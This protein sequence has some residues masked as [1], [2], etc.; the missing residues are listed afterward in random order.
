MCDFSVAICVYHRDSTELFRLAVESVTKYQSKKPSEVIIVVDGPIHGDL[1]DYVSS[2]EKDRLF[3]VVRLPENLGHAGARQAGLMAASNN[4]VAIMDADDISVPDRFEKQIKA[5]E[6]NPHIAVIGGQINEFIGS[7]DNIVGTRI[8][9]IADADIKKY[10]KGRCP[11]NL[12]TVMFR[13]DYVQAV[14]GYQEWFCEEDYYLWIRLAKAGYTFKNLP[15]N[16]VNVR[17]GDEMYRRRGGWKYFKSEAGLQGYMLKHGVI[18]L[19]RYCFNVL[20]RFAIQVAMPNKLRGFIFQ[21]L[22][23]K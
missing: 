1:D 3:K 21:K 14:G 9:P 8:V 19:P 12:V 15:D 7:Q 6:E 23:R 13:K 17:V 22:F 2:L 16:L 11:M 4:L 10:L 18:S 5:Y 20:G